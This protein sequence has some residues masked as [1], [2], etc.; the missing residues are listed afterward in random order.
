MNKE[1]IEEEIPK[2]RK[3]TDSS[4]SKS[5]S[6]AKHKHKYIK[7]LFVS[8]IYGKTIYMPGGYCELCGKIND[9]QFN[10]VERAEGTALYSSLSSEEVLDKFKHLPIVKL[11][12]PYTQKYVPITISKE[13]MKK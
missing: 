3:K 9:I 8:D 11:Q 4:K 6:K 1:F 13:E 7:C 5:R 12:D 10:V 2:Y